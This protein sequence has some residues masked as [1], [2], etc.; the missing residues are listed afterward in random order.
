MYDFVSIVML[1]TMLEHKIGVVE[2]D[3]YY[4]QLMK[5]VDRKIL[6]TYIHTYISS[7]MDFSM[8]NL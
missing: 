4:L 8:T 7:Y 1:P 3:L 5:N 2:G 6:H